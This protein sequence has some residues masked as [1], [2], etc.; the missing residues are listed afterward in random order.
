MTCAQASVISCLE[1]FA[2][3]NSWLKAGDGAEK[4]C[5]LLSSARI[6]QVCR[7]LARE[8]VLPLFQFNSRAS[9]IFLAAAVLWVSSQKSPVRFG[10]YA[11]RKR[12]CVLLHVA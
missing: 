11:G 12:P 2:T 5:S 8:L 9:G 7:F 3:E 1:Q 6:R 4:A 10:W